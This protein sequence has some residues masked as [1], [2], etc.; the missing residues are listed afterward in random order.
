MVN[1]SKKW[2]DQIWKR[3]CYIHPMSHYVLLFCWQ[4]NNA[5]Y[6]IFTSK[7]PPFRRKHNVNYLL[8]SSAENNSLISASSVTNKMENTDMSAVAGIY[9]CARI[10]HATW[11]LQFLSHS[12][13]RCSEYSACSVDLP[14]L[15]AGIHSCLWRLTRGFHSQCRPKYALVLHS[16]LVISESVQF[17]G[18]SFLMF[19]SLH[20][21]RKN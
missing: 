8:N 20:L 11:L 7:M 6:P 18:Q 5:S 14:R 9:N 4:F 17:L 1:V 15:N 16:S 10:N 19:S 2:G 21:I 13:L 3:K 12:P